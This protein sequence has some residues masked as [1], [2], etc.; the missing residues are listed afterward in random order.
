MLACMM[1]PS[2]VVEAVK[3]EFGIT[4]KR[5]QVWGYDPKNEQP[6]SEPLKDLFAKT[7]KA[8][9]EQTI[10][11][12]VAN[13]AHRLNRLDR[14]A[15]KAERSRN[16]PLAAQL[17]EQ[18]AKECGGLYTNRQKIE[19]KV[20]GEMVTMSV[21]DW[22]RRAEERRKQAAETMAEFEDDTG[23]DPDTNAPES[24]APVIPTFA[25]ES[26]NINEIGYH[27]SSKTVAVLFK[28]GGLYHVSP[29]E[30]ETF[31]AFQGAESKGKFYHRHFKDA[32]GL[33]VT[34]VE[35]QAGDAGE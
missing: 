7:R 1:S 31:L 23:E 13:Q 6:L 30:R 32:E 20:T 9:E 22:K 15:I 24:A 25:V 21:E 34:K 29:V 8:W 33:S 26:S 27:E 17:L 4:L 3:D 11:V 19:A 18:I 10:A 12:R 2:E 35:P 16:L 28:S 14:L 5:Q